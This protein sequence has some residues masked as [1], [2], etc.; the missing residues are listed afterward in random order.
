MGLIKSAWN[1]AKGTL[2]DQWKEYFYCDAL[3]ADVLMA[4]GEKHV[5]G[6][7]ANRKGEDNVIRTARTS[8][9]RTVSV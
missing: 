4:R 2:A 1:A 3:D 9:W 6:R 8:P 7:T 5:S